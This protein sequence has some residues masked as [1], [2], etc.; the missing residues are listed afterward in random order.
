MPTDRKN[1]P[2]RVRL[3]RAAVPFCGVSK[4]TKDGR[5][6]VV[7]VPGG[8]GK[9]YSVILKRNSQLE[10]ECRLNF[11]T[12]GMGDLCRGNGV[13]TICK[14]GMTAVLVAAGEAKMDVAWC[15]TE[16]D[17]V[18]RG[19][20]GADHIMQIVNESGGYL[21]VVVEGRGL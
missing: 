13:H 17:A 6:R 11:G 14:H 5:P 7:T 21:Y 1:L 3:A 8:R 9:R 2:N 20:I 4:R 18:M 16:Y 19:R 10:V 15:A 12:L